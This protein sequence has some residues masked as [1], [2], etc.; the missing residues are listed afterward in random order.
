MPDLASRPASGQPQLLFAAILLALGTAPTQAAPALIGD[1]VLSSGSFSNAVTGTAALGSLSP[2]VSSGSTGFV[3][4]TASDAGWFWNGATAPGTGLILSGLPLNTGTG[5]G[6]AFGSYSIGM[7][8]QFS[9]VSG[10][11]RMITFSPS[12]DSGMY[13]ENGQFNF[14]EATQPK[15]NKGG[16]IT[17]GSFVDFV[18]TRSGAGSVT[19]YVNGSSTPALTAF[20]DTANAG[21]VTSGSLQFFRDNTGGSDFSPAGRVSLLRIWNGPLAAADI[22]MAMVPEPSALALVGLGVAAILVGAR[23]RRRSLGR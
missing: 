10:Y 16:T 14:F 12:D 8:F 9:E 17:S 22:P 3:T 19:W 20:P 21:A 13:V 11:R 1:Y 15:S 2:I 23:Y 18:L 4:G 5:A 6:A 7:R